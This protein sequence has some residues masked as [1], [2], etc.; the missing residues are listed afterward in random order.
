MFFLYKRFFKL[1][2]QNAYEGFRMLNKVHEK[3]MSLSCQGRKW[4]QGDMFCSDSWVREF[5]SDVVVNTYYLF[6]GNFFACVLKLFQ[7]NDAFA[8]L[9]PL[10]LRT[11]S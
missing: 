8:P 7:A 11:H 10:N 3:L 9:V 5:T 1:A 4:V 2:D 6:F